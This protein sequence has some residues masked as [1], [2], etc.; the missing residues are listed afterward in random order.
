MDL[1]RISAIV[2][3]L[4]VN[5]QLRFDPLGPDD[6][7]QAGQLLGR[8]FGKWR[9]RAQP[10]SLSAPASAPRR[11][12]HYLRHRKDDA[13]LSAYLIRHFGNQFADD[14]FTDAMQA[15]GMTLQ[16]QEAEVAAAY[17]LLPAGLAEDV[18]D[19]ISS[20]LTHALYCI[21]AGRQGD[22]VEALYGL[23][24]LLPRI[25]VVCRT[26]TFGSG[27]RKWIAVTG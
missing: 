27:H 24:E 18:A 22:D 23:C 7:S 5:G 14:N 10:L 21:L 16:L 1:H 20:L 13:L 8:L 11:V 3:S 4:R 19:S 9:N 15:V 25:A 17:P 26:E 2:L 6:V 12:E